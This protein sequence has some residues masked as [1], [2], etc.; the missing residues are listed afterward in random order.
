MHQ[1]TLPPEVRALSNLISQVEHSKLRRELLR[2]VA[3]Y[4]LCKGG[5]VELVLYPN[6][7]LV[8]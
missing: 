2:A 1:D 7:P 8:L 6:L 4:R 5:A 3:E